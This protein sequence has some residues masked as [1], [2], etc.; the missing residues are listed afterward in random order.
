MDV[1]IVHRDLMNVTA[2]TGRV[3]LMSSNAVMTVCVSASAGSVMVTVTAVMGPTNPTV[4]MLPVLPT[5]GGATVHSASHRH[6]DVTTVLT[7]LTT[8]T[9]LAVHQ[10]FQDTLP[11]IHATK[12]NSNVVL[13][14]VSIK[15]GSVTWIMTV[16]MDQMKLT[17]SR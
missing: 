16:R 3:H 6:G 10:P 15:R 2:T 7:V 9:S 4:R 5:S 14:N 8:Q 11:D 13:A 1:R 12:G 17:V